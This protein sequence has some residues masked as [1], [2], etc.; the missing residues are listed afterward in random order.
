MVLA[1]D[2]DAAAI[3]KSANSNRALD[4]PDLPSVVPVTPS[5]P[6]PIFSQWEMPENVT[7]SSKKLTT[8]VKNLTGMYIR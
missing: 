7:G 2:I 3:A 1:L 5:V 6:S 4:G 8:A